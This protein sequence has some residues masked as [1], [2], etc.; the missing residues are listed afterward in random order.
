MN[1]CNEWFYY[2]M[3][4]ITNSNNLGN[5]GVMNVKIYHYVVIFSNIDIYLSVCR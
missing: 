5:L 4:F 3:T 2:I 1:D